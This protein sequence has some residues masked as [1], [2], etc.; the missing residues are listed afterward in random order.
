MLY[1]DCRR[2]IV[3]HGRVEGLKCS[4]NEYMTTDAAPRTA[5]VARRGRVAGSTQAV[6]RPAGS[7]KRRCAAPACHNDYSVWQLRRHEIQYTNF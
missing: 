2:R 1:N 4:T 5:A 3:L 6:G 7:P